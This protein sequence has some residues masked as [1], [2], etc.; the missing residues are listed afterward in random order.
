MAFKLIARNTVTVPV[1]G[2]FTLD[3]G[4]KELFDFKLTCRRQG[5]DEQ[6]AALKNDDKSVKAFMQDVVQGFSGVLDEDGNQVTYSEETLDALL[7][8]PGIAQ[9]A[10]R[11]YLEEQGAKAKN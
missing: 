5:A 11:A 8:T 1:K 9:L 4:K 2:F 3:D 7:E 10:F 6:L